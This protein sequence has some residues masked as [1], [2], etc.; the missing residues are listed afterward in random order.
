MCEIKLSIISTQTEA[1]CQHFPPCSLQLLNLSVSAFSARQLFMPRC[2]T[3]ASLQLSVRFSCAWRAT[4]EKRCS[5]ACIC[6]HVSG[7]VDMLSHLMRV[8]VFFR[9]GWR[10]GHALPRADRGSPAALEPGQ[11]RR[12]LQQQQDVRDEPVQPLRHP[13]PWPGVPG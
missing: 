2:A 9:H 11:L 8:W 5:P 13:L 12:R 3:N 7:H 6:T 10:Q 1:A 4:H